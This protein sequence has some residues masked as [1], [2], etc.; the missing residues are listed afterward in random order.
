MRQAVDHPPLVPGQE[1]DEG[2]RIPGL[3]PFDHRPERSDGRLG[4]R[5]GGL[6]TCGVGKIAHH[7]SLLPGIT[8]C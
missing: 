8:E 4:R 2:R 3:G 6:E 1:L 5:V 7:R